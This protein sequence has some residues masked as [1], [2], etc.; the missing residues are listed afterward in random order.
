MTTIAT[1]SARALRSVLHR[2]GFERAYRAR[3]LANPHAVLSE[4]GVAVPD[5]V[6]LRP[7]EATP[8]RA[9][10]VLRRPVGDDAVFDAILM[11]LND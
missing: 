6:T 9:Y 3:L 2:A 8:E 5:G 11:R 4:A 7:L 1:V 10:L